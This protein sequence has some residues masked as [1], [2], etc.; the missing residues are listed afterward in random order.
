MIYGD[1]G[2]PDSGLSSEAS[3]VDFGFSLSP[4]VLQISITEPMYFD[5]DIVHLVDDTSH[6]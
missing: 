6:W 5:D 3:L 2:V 1:I 4:K